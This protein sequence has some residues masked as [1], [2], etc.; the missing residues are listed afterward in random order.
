ML[1]TISV[2]KQDKRTKSGEK[3]KKKYDREFKNRKAV[4]EHAAKLMADP[5]IRIEINE[6]MVEVRNLQSGK[7]V[8]QRYDTPRSCDVSSELYWSM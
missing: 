3:L 2:F 6:T 1:Y 8:L 7:M 4:D 5:K